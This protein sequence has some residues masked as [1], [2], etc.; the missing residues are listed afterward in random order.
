MAHYPHL[1]MPLKVGAHY[2]SNRL[3]LAPLS[4]G[5]EE[6]GE[7]SPQL[8][9]FYRRR[10][11]SQG[12]GLVILGD[13]IVHFSGIRNIGD[14]ILSNSWF[15]SAARLTKAIH[16]EGAKTILQL[17]HH[18]ADSQHLFSVAASGSHRKDRAFPVHR[19]PG[20]LAGQ[21]IQT[22]AQRAYCAVNLSQFDGVEVDGGKLSLPSTFSTPALNRRNDRYG[23]SGRLNF[24]VEVV[25]RIRGFI[26]PSPI[27]AYRLSLIDLDP[28]GNEWHDL[29]AFAQ[30][31][32]YEGVN[33]FSFDIG[34]RENAIPTK[35][36][37]TPEG[38]WCDFM[39][40][41]SNEIH[42]PV[43]FGTQ[44]KNPEKM[45][46]L[47][48]R[49]IT[50]MVEAARPYIAD[51]AWA[52]KLRMGREEEIIPCV[53]CAQRC[54]A[55]THE[56]G[57]RLC[58][59]ANPNLFKVP[60]KKTE[61]NVLVVGGGP[62]G[63]AAA[64][65][66]ALMGYQVT[67]A[68]ENDVLG[69]LWRLCA[70]IPGREN[71]LKLLEKQEAELASLGVNILKNTQVTGV[72]IEEHCGH[73]HIILATGRESVIPDIPG[74]DNL[75]VL[76]FEDLLK[77]GMPVGHRV[78]VIGGNL[79][80]VDIARYLCAPTVENP[81]AW[82]R[83]WGIGDPA[84]HQG[85][86][87]GVIPSL[88]EPPRKLYL[89]NESGKSL[90]KI[91]SAQNRAFELQWLRMHGANILEDVRIDQIDSFS[92]RVRTDDTAESTAVFKIDHVVIADV[93]EPR[94]ELTIELSELD[95][96]YT[97]AGSVTQL[98]SAYSAAEAVNDAV[99]TVRKLIP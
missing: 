64:R 67:L 93:L 89:V 54:F 86:M 3:A 5:L 75:N 19:L 9:D 79:L 60:P 33:L 34:L 28:R 65:E 50:C 11:A 26:G 36:E 76:T 90:E 56:F 92:I 32:R 69:G 73:A 84:K 8:I 14:P 10:V 35:S 87:L 12:A 4:T 13:G 62:A 53:N 55:R 27:L 46:S 57:K 49:N 1:F 96:P 23:F 52:V 88:D 21:L 30:A 40:K 2:L 77:N 47:L 15:N 99:E 24:S 31:L 98:R 51:E 61:G 37:L 22:Y 83:A 43:I 25:K 80:T 95:R 41:F 63:M 97:L 71:I 44:L 48:T 85:G 20:L 70:M 17:T 81:D 72:W 66:A 94:D 59:A 68:E 6:Q 7:I 58:C 91:L 74:I 45:E 39:E 82:L 42:V 38:V 78:A 18:G 29:L 16:D